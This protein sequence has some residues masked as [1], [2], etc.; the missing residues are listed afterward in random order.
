MQREQRVAAANAQP[1][2]VGLVLPAADDVET[3]E[4]AQRSRCMMYCL[5]DP[6]PHLMYSSQSKYN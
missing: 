5:I 2:T 1:V 6:N 3:D 4:D